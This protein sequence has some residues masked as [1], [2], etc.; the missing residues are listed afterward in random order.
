MLIP[1]LCRDIISAVIQ[2]VKLDMS[3]GKFL[4]EF[5]LL[6]EN[7]QLQ[8]SELTYKFP[9]EAGV[10]KLLPQQQYGSL[11]ARATV[12]IVI[13]GAME[14]ELWYQLYKFLA[15][16]QI[17]CRKPT[18]ATSELS[19]NMYGIIIKIFNIRPTFQ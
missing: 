15:R 14:C 5:K 19:Y 16:L 11:F 10:F 6:V 12:S 4:V 1:F 18:T 8:E 9:Y 7:S 17:I 2:V 3:C 13:Q